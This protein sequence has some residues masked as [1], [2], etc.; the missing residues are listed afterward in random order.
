MTLKLQHGRLQKVSKIIASVEW[1][2]E[3][4]KE[5]Y[6][7]IQNSQIRSWNCRPDKVVEVVFLGR[8]YHL[9]PDQTILRDERGVIF[10][11]PTSMDLCETVLVRKA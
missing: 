2:G 1:T 11:M 4:W 10:I 8:R 3:N 6:D 7:F 9:K 5:V